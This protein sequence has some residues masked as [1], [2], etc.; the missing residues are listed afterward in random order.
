MLTTLTPLLQPQSSQL[1]LTC[2]A[3]T[4]IRQRLKLAMARG[5]VSAADLA[6]ACEI[7]ASAVSKWLREDAKADAT[8]KAENVFPIAKLCRVDAE[9]LATGKG[10]PDI[11]KP[12][13][14]AADIPDHR[15]ELIRQYGR[16]PKEI[17]FHIRAL[18]Q[19]LDVANSD[20]Y[21]RWSSEM[22]EKAKRRDELAVHEP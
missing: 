21:A 14:R 17:R 16:L 15:L 12:T 2:R 11:P 3:V 1:R 9:W 10:K 8:I 13:G 6:K 20:T 5:D 19:T 22:S 4:T 7:S 18:I